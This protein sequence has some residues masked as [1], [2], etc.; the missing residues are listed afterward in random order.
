[1]WL[2]RSGK[3]FFRLDEE[4][5]TGQ[6]SSSSSLAWSSFHSWQIWTQSVA[7]PVA[8]NKLAMR[9]SKPGKPRRQR[10]EASEA[11]WHSGPSLIWAIVPH[12]SPSLVAI[13]W[14]AIISTAPGWWQKDN[15]PIRSAL[16]PLTSFVSQT[17][18]SNGYTFS[19]SYIS[20]S[21]LKC[22]SYIGSVYIES[23]YGSS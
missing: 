21:L 22:S 14:C 19:S 3:I 5:S 6:L 10:T 13:Q 7:G 11:V 1:M 20:S 18:A 8:C 16:R 2:W 9:N 12:N 17:D 4:E 23:I 15:H